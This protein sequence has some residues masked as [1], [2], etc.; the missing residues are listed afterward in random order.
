[1]RGSNSLATTKDTSILRIF[2]Y[3]YFESNIIY[4][5][6]YGLHHLIPHSLLDQMTKRED[7]YA[8]PWNSLISAYAESDFHVDALAFYVHMVEEGFDS[9][10][11]QFFTFFG[12]IIHHR[13]NS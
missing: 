12:L 2:K 8:F 4:E 5:T 6:C 10:L 9:L 13:Y 3:I 1:M 7:M 11:F